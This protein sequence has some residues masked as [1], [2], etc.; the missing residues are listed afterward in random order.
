MKKRQLNQYPSGTAAWVV[1]HGKWQAS[2]GR[3][4]SVS[5]HNITDPRLAL[6]LAKDDLVTLERLDQ[7]VA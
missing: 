6:L 1:A 2:R 4:P 3:G 5:Y 7:E